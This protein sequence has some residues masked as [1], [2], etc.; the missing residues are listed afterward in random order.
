MNKS[1]LILILIVVNMLL[2]VWVFAVPFLPKSE[3]S[4]SIKDVVSY[5]GLFATLF[6]FCFSFVLL[7][8]G[9]NILSIQK[10]ASRSRD[11]VE[12]LAEKIERKQKQLASSLRLNDISSEALTETLL[13][14]QSSELFEDTQHADYNEKNY[15]LWENTGHLRQIMTAIKPGT[16]VE[17]IRAVREV[18]GAIDTSEADQQQMK[19]LGLARSVG[20]QILLEIDASEDLEVPVRYSL[21]GQIDGL[22]AQAEPI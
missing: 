13:L 18:V 11:L 15:I 20:E 4:F 5:A 21:I 12:R 9:L 14:L 3:M 2:I 16:F 19:I 10:E 8:L 7:I 6:A 22:L 17:R 1:S